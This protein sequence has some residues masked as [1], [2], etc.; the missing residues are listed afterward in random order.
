MTGY[1]NKFKKKNKQCLLWLKINN[2]RKLQQ[3]M[4]KN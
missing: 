4:E 1:I 2:F 3:N